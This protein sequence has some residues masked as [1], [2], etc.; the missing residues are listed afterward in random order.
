MGYGGFGGALPQ[1]IGARLGRPDT[2]VV[3]VIGDGGF[4]FTGMKLAVAV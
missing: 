3:C 4:Q 2:P 1:A